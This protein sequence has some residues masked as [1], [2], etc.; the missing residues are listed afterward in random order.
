MP[1][2]ISNQATLQYTY[3]ATTETVTSNIA[4]TVMQEPL[5]VAKSTLESAYRADSELTYLINL[6]NNSQTVLTNVTVTDNLG[7]YAL[8]PTQSATPLYYNDPAQLYIDGVFSASL[9]PTPGI[10]SITFRIPSIPAGANALIL[11]KADVNTQAQLALGS[12]ITN[13]VSVTATGQTEPVT[14][15]H[16]IDADVYADVR[17]VKAMSPNPV[18][19]GG[20]LTYTFTVYNY[21]NA[22]ATDIVL[23]DAFSPAP[24]QI[25]VS[26]NG[27]VIDPSN[28][29]YSGGT[30]TLPTAGA[31]LSLTVPAA[32]F[33]Q[34]PATGV[35]SVSPGTAT[36]IVTGTI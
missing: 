15:T 9:T 36:I 6:T 11:Y 1:T 5:S 35:V 3:G 29:S 19:D 30:L 2:T 17:V 31:A 13:T 25:S 22:A 8:S 20:Q 16:T 7:T 24:S 28:Y 21:G 18:T 12:E 26:L 27:A 4:T 33:R 32:T 34:N 14:A 10:R 23:S